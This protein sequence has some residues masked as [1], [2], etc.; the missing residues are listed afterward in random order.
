MLVKLLYL[1]VC[2]WFEPLKLACRTHQTESS[3][4]STLLLDYVKQ[5][6]SSVQQDSH[7]TNL[8]FVK[9]ENCF[10]RITDACVPVYCTKYGG[11]YN[12]RNEA[13]KM[14]ESP[15]WKTAEAKLW[16]KAEM[17]FFSWKM[18]EINQGYN[19]LTLCQFFFK[20]A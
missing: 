13:R 19:L 7:P 15:C 17:K 18:A 11:T 20:H 14:F 16:M 8:F 6:T 10:S 4:S 9:G 1:Q 2:I 5:Q 3:V 12:G